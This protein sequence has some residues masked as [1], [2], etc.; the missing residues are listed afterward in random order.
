MRRS[1]GFTLI[2]LLV[3]IA[4]IGVL[5][6]LL[7]P[8]VQAAREA[9]RRSQCVNNLKQIGLA[10]HN[11]HQS[12][13]SLPPSGEAFSNEY[14][15]LGWNAGPQNFS[16]K[17]RILPYMEAGNAFNSVNFAVTAIWGTGPASPIDGFSINYSIR[18]TKI[19]SYFCPSDTNDP[20]TDD[21]QLPGGSYG[22]NR[23]MNRYNDNWY[24]T[25]INYFQG[26]DGA[27]NKTRNFASITDGLS[28]TAAFSEWVKGKGLM[29]TD[30]AHMTYAIPNGT[31]TIP[32]GAADAHYQLALL[33]QA[34]TSR[35]WDYKGEVWTLHDG[36]RGGGYS[37]IQP[38]NRKA[39]NQSGDESLI[40]ASS[41]HP[42]GVNLL[43]CDGSVKFAKNGIGIRVWH[44]LHTIGNGETI[45]GDTFGN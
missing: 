41:Y 23:G 27:R 3:V 9:A 44:A 11:Y 42:G 15:A 26:H 13:D 32:F 12:N 38:P 45:P 6:A 2:E 24:F 14:P 4:I 22:E 39:C 25:G 36:V 20:G 17:V 7:L 30:G 8:A 34:T 18:H 40:G 29:L 10:L 19:A 28:Q 21:P 5:I 1:R 43:L 33:C 16:M 37:G 35:S 31:T